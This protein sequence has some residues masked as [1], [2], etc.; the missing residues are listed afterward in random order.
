MPRYIPVENR[1]WYTI[2][3]VAEIL[4]LSIPAAKKWLDE[5]SVEYHRT[6]GGHRRIPKISFERYL[7]GYD[8]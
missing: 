8:V 3:E 6:R 7:D 2:A 4:R 5:H 1:Q